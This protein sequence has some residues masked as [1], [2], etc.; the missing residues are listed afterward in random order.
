MQLE[1]GQRAASLD[2]DADRLV[3]F[4]LDT[5]GKFKLLDGDKI[6]TL[7]LLFHSSFSLLCRLKKFILIDRL[8]FIVAGY[9]KKLVKESGLNLN[10]GLVQ[11]AYANGS[12]TEYINNTLVSWVSMK[13]LFNSYFMFFIV[14]LGS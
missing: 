13:C 3:Y 2:G 12:S 14:M 7:G 5:Q 1:V 10:M 11:T 8:I 9:L 4:Y 6:A